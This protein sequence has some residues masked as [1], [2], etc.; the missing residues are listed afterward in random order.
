[1]RI[2][3]AIGKLFLFPALGENT[4]RIQNHLRVQR[5]RNRDR[6]LIDA[7]A[8]IVACIR[9]GEKR[10]EVEIIQMGGSTADLREQAAATDDFLQ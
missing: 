6:P 10:I 8:W 7:I 9:F 4:G 1:M 3:N 2:A 5:F